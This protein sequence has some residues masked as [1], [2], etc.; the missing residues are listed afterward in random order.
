M[1]REHSPGKV[2]YEYNKNKIKQLYRYKAKFIPG[3]MRRDT[4]IET[5]FNKLRKFVV[6]C[7]SGIFYRKLTCS[8]KKILESKKSF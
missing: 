7:E 2:A 5:K 3:A 6:S 8:E 4:T 1:Y